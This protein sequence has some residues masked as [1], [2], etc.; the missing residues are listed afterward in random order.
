MNQNEPKE[1]RMNLAGEKSIDCLELKF[2]SFLKVIFLLISK[3]K[4]LPFLVHIVK[5]VV[6]VHK[7]GIKNEKFRGPLGVSSPI[8]QPPT[9]STQILHFE[10]GNFSVR[11][12]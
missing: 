12:L 10:L 3:L 2:H 8:V 9:Q 11:N 7:H 1:D 5:G 4:N 6:L